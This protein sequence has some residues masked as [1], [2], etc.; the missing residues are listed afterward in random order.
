MYYAKNQLSQIQTI[1][2]KI[3]NE[4]NPTQNSPSLKLLNNY[5]YLN[6]AIKMDFLFMGEP[7]LTCTVCNL[8][9]FDVKQSQQFVLN[10]GHI[11]NVCLALWRFLL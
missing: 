10:K 7:T 8:L 3:M 6:G 9:L 1:N 2:N 5:V 4:K 11:G